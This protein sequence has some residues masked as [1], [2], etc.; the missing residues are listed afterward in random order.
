[1]YAGSIGLNERKL[2]LKSA[3]MADFVSSGISLFRPRERSDGS[4]L[5]RSCSELLGEP[6]QVSEAVQA[7]PS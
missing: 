2:V 7:T 6:T 4:A 5:R 1:M 3:Y